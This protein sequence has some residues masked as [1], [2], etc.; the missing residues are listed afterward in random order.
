LE[1]TVTFPGPYP[2]GLRTPFRGEL[3]G[4]DFEFGEISGTPPQATVAVESEIRLAQLRLHPPK[5]VAGEEESPAIEVQD[6]SEVSKFLAS[7][8]HA[9]AFITDSPMRYSVRGRSLIPECPED[10]A[11]FER[12]GTRFVY[13]SLT[14]SGSMRSF[15]LESLTPEFLSALIAKE[16][17]LAM[18]ARALEHGDSAAS[19]RELW[20]ILE[21]AFGAKDRKLV[22][23]LARFE[24]ATGM[25]FTTQELKALLTLRG[26]ASH[27]NSKK[28]R[29]EYQAVRH[30]TDKQLPRLKS[31]VE[32]VVL[33][34]RNWGADDVDIE[35]LLRLEAYV[36][37]KGE[38]TLLRD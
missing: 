20:R 29:R 22:A 32:Q 10:E 9:F 35:P 4:R 34:K 24:P 12:F 37:P 2:R 11:L 19:Y 31:L 6:T 25:E 14:M 30:E 3:L 5:V 15:L 18:Y 7:V 1:Y 8:I 33:T 13:P 27:L 36:N 26:R 17:A 16:P 21:S 23:A 28:G 38:V